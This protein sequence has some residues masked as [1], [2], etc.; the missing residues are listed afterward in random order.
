MYCPCGRSLAKAEGRGIPR[1]KVEKRSLGAACGTAL[2][3]EAL[4]CMVSPGCVGAHVRVKERAR[5]KERG[6]Q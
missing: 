2:V 3:V 5:A 4:E 1:S 6:R